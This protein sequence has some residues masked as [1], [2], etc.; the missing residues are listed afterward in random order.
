MAD[1]IKDGVITEQ[2]KTPVEAPEGFE[3]LFKTL[4]AMKIT[5]K[6]DNPEELKQ[7]MKEFLASQGELEVKPELPLPDP[8]V[9]PKYKPMT[10]P[11]GFEVKPSTPPSGNFPQPPKLSIFYGSDKK[12]EV[13]YDFWRHHVHCLLKD[14]IYNKDMVHKNIRQSLRGEAGRVVMRLGVN[15]TIPQI[16]AKLDSIYG[17]IDN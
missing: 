5:P 3:N 12:G 11:S 6:A 4:K 17:D 13:S 7:W 9:K 15:A 8:G 16:L 10:L 1:G 2:P 14:K